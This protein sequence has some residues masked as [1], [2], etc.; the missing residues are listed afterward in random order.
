MNQRGQVTVMVAG[1][2]LICFA[3]AGLAVDATRAFLFRRTLQ[4]GADASALAGAAELD[5]ATFRGAGG[6]I[7]VAQRA[8]ETM[9]IA[10]V[11]QRRLPVRAEVEAAGDGVRVL[12]RGEVSTT[13]LGLVGIDDLPV[14]A[15]AEAT[16]LAGEP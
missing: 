8:A 7:S 2:A 4:N 11:R 16:P 15:V 9:A 10:Y 3:L 6:R 13:L 12:L 5:E 14:S 1:L